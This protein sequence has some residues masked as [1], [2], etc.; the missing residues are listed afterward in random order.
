MKFK[1]H[2]EEDVFDF[3]NMKSLLPSLPAPRQYCD[4]CEVFDQHDTIDC[5]FDEHEIDTHSH[6]DGQRGGLRLFCDIC[7]G[8]A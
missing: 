5:P 8:Y 1:K 4:I 6:F 3:S 2:D 7:E